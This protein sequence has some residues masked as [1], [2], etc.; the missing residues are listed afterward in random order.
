MLDEKRMEKY[1][2]IYDKRLYDIQI[3]NLSISPYGHSGT[4]NKSGGSKQSLQS[5]IGSPIKSPYAMKQEII[6]RLKKKQKKEIQ[7]MIEHEFKINQIKQ[8]NELNL[9]LQ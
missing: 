7:I 9:K 8:K 4:P 6:D 3:S 1:K 5:L 2:A